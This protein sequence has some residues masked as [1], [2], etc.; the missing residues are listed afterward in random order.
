MHSVVQTADGGYIATGVGPLG[1]VFRGLTRKQTF[2]RVRADSRFLLNWVVLK[3][4]S[5]GNPRCKIVLPNGRSWMLDGSCVAPTHDGG[6]VF[7]GSFYPGD[8]L[9]RTNSIGIPLWIKT[10]DDM[11]VD[12]C[13]QTEDGGYILSDGGRRIR[14]LAPEGK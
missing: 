7:S 14:K 1:L 12:C 2:E 11:G 9:I 4:D 6:Y 13:Q 10:F 8:C 3:T 5:K